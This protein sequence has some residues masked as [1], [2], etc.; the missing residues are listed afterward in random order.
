MGYKFI[1]VNAYFKKAEDQTVEVAQPLT[2]KTYNQKDKTSQEQAF[3]S[4][5]VRGHT[6][7]QQEHW[8]QAKEIFEMKEI[9]NQIFQKINGQD[10]AEEWISWMEDKVEMII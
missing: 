4:T 3:G 7:R 10:H 1:A 5:G 8:K 2:A 9:I 6:V